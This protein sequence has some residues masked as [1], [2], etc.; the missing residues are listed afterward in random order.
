MKKLKLDL[1]DLTVESFATTP[2]SRGEG[3][4]VF[5]QNHCTCYTQC[6]CP[7]CPTCDA[8]CNGTC[9]GTCDASCNGT[10]G[11]T[12]DFSCGDTCYETCGYTCQTCGGRDE[13]G[14]YLCADY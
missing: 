11:G 14:L 5:G 13:R 8:S 3:G 2:E 7:G 10:C 4:T 1:E 12:C 6:T 9:G